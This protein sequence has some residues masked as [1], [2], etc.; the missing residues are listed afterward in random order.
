MEIRIGMETRM[1]PVLLVVALS[2]GCS[3]P[4]SKESS[5]QESLEEMLQEI[6]NAAAIAWVGPHCDDE[7]VVSGLL[8]LSSFHYNKDTYVVSLNEGATAFPPG[9]TLEDRHQ[10]NMDFKNFL[11]L[12]G[13]IRLGLNKYKENRKKSYMNFWMNLLL[14][15]ESIFS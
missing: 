8:A 3:I 12:K 1:I 13:Y 5:P 14:K 11:N 4:F 10:D 7:I 6:E 15:Q 2:A 9:A